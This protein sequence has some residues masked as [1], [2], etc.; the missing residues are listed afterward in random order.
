MEDDDLFSE[1]N[2]QPSRPKPKEFLNKKHPRS[3]NSSLNAQP[4][5][6]Y[7]PDTSI[8]SIPFENNEKVENVL[9]RK[10]ITTILPKFNPSDYEN[11]T[12]NNEND[13]STFLGT[14]IETNH[15]KGGIHETIYPE[16]YD[17]TSHATTY[18]NN[19]KSS[20]LS[21]TSPPKPAHTF[22][23]EL[24][25]FQKHAVNCLEKHQSVLV[26]AHTSAGKTVVAQYAIA[27]ALRDKQ[28]V[29]YTSPIKALSNQKYREL[30]HD[31]KDVGLMTG[32]V[33][34][35]PDASCIVM[36]TEILRNM[37]FKGSEITREMA[38]VIFDEVHYMRDKER[39]V[40]WEE[41]IILLSNKINYVFLSATIPNAREFA[42]WIA[43]IKSQPCNVVYTEYRPVPL[44]HY[45]HPTGGTGIYLVVNA[46]GEFKENNFQ[47]ALDVIKNEN[48]LDKKKDMKQDSKLDTKKHLKRIV[49]LIKNENLC[50]AIVFSFSKKDC[51]DNAISLSKMD[52]TTKEEKELIDLIY[53][54][55]IQTLSE[56]D[57]N[58]P[59]I[60]S[61]LTILKRG[62]GIHHGGM[63]PIVKECVELLFQEGLIK[64]L[65]STETFSMGIN[66]PAK[67]VVF[68]SV[69]KWDGEQHRWLAGSEYIQMSGRAG[70]R[71]ID[72]KGI[73][74]MMLNKNLDIESCKGML[75]GQ[76]APLESSFHLNYNQ[77][78]NLMRLEGMESEYIVKRSFRQFQN[79]R[80]V[81]KLK[82]NLGVLYSKYM[83]IDK[84]DYDRDY[85]LYEIYSLYKKIETIDED[86]HDKVITPSNVIPFLRF[87]RLVK[88]KG[89]GY[90][91]VVSYKK[92]DIEI[93]E[94]KKQELQTQFKHK[95][96]HN[97]SD[98]NENTFH[99]DYVIDVIVYI[100]PYT[101]SNSRVIPADISEGNGTLGI[102]PF[103]LNALEG[104]SA[105]I[106]QIPLKLK[107]NENMKLT[108][109]IFMEVMKRH[110]NTLPLMDPIKDMQII[111]KKLIALVNNKSA[112]E[113]R[114]NEIKNEFHSTYGTH[115]DDSVLNEYI[116][117]VKLR[118]DI[119]ALIT[120]ITN[121]QKIVLEDEFTCMKRVLRR[122]DFVNE[123]EILSTK[124]QVGCN[125]SAGDEL[126][127]TE[128][129][130]NGSL[131]EVEGDYLVAFLTCFLT[132]ENSGGNTPNGL[133]GNTSNS[134]TDYE[135][136][137]KLKD[138]FNKLKE[139]AQRVND[140]L[141]DC[142]VPFDKT[143]E[144]VD[145]FKSDYML[146]VFMWLNGKNIG[147]ICV[148]I[149]E[150]NFIRIIRR[151]DE[152]IKELVESSE[153]IGITDLKD[154]L[155]TSAV[156]L[157]RGLPF[158]ASLYLPAN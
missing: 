18:N 117:K 148:N 95:G 89:F 43:K 109:K 79:M 121:H 88:V 28:R 5:S 48:K 81:P 85:M 150:G 76:A 94:T 59:A 1:F 55:A 70:R 27:M 87:G 4:S 20:S 91:I 90:G 155:N 16:N 141:V 3:H 122:L 128:M 103:A 82:H 147:D 124:G 92:T 19:I 71:G 65:F 72:D 49:T 107:E 29:I 135:S 129:L 74:I 156:K 139:N 77:L 98:T 130:F 119:N 39:G 126:L 143:N 23:F 96:K 33:T 9:L 123:N 68:T 101:E 133:E 112:L 14:T 24:D 21:S 137:K 113:Q 61:M 13:P 127:L 34:R 32:D 142:K 15:F 153:L 73:T 2:L 26:S 100:S 78:L 114:I 63:L 37:L 38:W 40:V 154:K 84:G 120:A 108:E 152:L 69:E 46:K 80:A 145:K 99:I 157:R 67:T 64:V 10:H 93:A 104:V 35:N 50:P 110:N 8:T 52:F 25:E 30:E 125:I 115:V 118:D 146:P 51:E 7:I 22:P 36:T 132:N 158:A 54:N 97:E 42:M 6:S 17:K 136:V 45:I 11:A 134:E 105:I 111:D 116:N 151:L 53:T 44:Q 12:V 86:I 62:F 106:A 56:E 41:T 31:F 58:L 47:K 57:M 149:Y 83:S 138:L 66:M 75:K 102:V 131:N 60:Q 144:Y 140:V